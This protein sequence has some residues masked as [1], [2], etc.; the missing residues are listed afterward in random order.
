MPVQSPPQERILTLKNREVAPV[1]IESV[2]HLGEK[3]TLRPR[4][5]FSVMLKKYWFYYILVLP[6][7]A[8]LLVFC[9]APMYGILV[10]FKEFNIKLGILFSPFAANHGFKYFLSFLHDPY[11]WQVMKNTILINLYR[12]AFGFTFTIFFALMLN[13]MRLRRMKK[14]VQV[15]TYLPY[16][17][18]WVIFAGLLSAILNPQN[19]LVNNVIVLLGGKPINFLGDNRYFQFLIVLSDTIK[20]AGYNSI[21]YLAAI[22]G[23]NPELY[24]SA[25]VD[26]AN[27]WHMI[28]SITLPAMYPTIA[29]LFMLNVSR[30]MASNFEQIYNLYSPLVWQT[31]DVAMTY[32]YR[33]GIDN[34]KFSLSTAISFFTSVIGLLLLVGTNGL[35]KRTEFEGVL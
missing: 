11:F 35:L 27:R 32:I 2:Q 6:G 19:G 1:E 33:L 34:S 7:L 24:E 14:V 30:I 17:L 31:G 25:K 9:Y 12:L 22:A 20:E 21:L 18:S 4:K 10:S 29:L 15:V 28:R 5:P 13:E 23:I 26:G 3:K 8:C 16:F